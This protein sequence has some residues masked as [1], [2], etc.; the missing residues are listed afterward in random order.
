[1]LIKFGIPLIAAMAIGFGIATLSHLTPKEQL[2][3]APN[4]P[5]LTQLGT[6]TPFLDWVK[7]RWLVSRLQLQLPCRELSRK[8]MCSLAKASPR[9][10]PFLTLDDRAMRAELQHR[11]AALATAMARLR[12]LKAGTRPEDLPP[13][14]A[15]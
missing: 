1:M 6:H 5:P 14:R 15:G 2:S 3:D 12:K 13:A 4:A 7:F 9:E 11:T 10:S 8:F